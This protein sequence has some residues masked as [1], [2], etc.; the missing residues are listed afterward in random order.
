MND[1]CRL[2]GQEA[3][4]LLSQR[5]LG[6]HDVNYF[7][8][9][10]CDL[11][12]SEQPHWLDE[13][14]SSAISALDTGAISRNIFCTRLAVVMARLLRVKRSEPCLDYGGGHGVFSR[15]MRDAGYNFRWCDKYGPNLYACG[16]EGDA[17]S[18][19]RFVTAFEVFEHLVQVREE[20]AMIFQPAHDFVLVGTVL[21]T[22][23]EKDWWYFVPETGQHVAFYS[24]RTLEHIGMTFGYQAFCGRAYSLLVRNQIRIGAWRRMLIRRY[25]N[26]TWLAYG[27]GSL[28]VEL[29][30]RRSLTWDDHVAL[31]RRTTSS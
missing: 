21:H 30:R 16:F 20:L 3:T 14:Y 23:P 7:R 25:L 10:A 22:N 29:G 31:K 2:C 24:P 1:Q 6:R 26:W 28:Q 9:P 18:T 27:I 19:Y 13:A 11:I 5:V 12:Q 8:C 4:Y 15:M 17:K